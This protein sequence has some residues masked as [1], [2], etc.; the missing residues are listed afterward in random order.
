MQGSKD[1]IFARLD[2]ILIQIS[3]WKSVWIW[4]GH[5]ADSYWCVP[6]RPDHELRPLDLML[7]GW[8]RWLHTCS[9]KWI[10][11]G[12]RINIGRQNEMGRGLTG[13]KDVGGEV[14][15]P[16]GLRR[17]LRWPPGDGKEWTTCSL[18]RRGRENYRWCWFLPGA[19]RRGDRSGS[20]RR[21]DAGEV[22][23][24]DSL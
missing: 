17:L 22:P 2:W 19:S 8:T 21:L 9:L 7:I 12:H 1:M 10:H 20:R 15:G 4:E 16:G 14:C 18:T 3:I 5:V 6:V 13:E 11:P 23:L 24:L